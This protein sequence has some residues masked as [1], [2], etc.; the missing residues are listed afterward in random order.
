MGPREPRHIWGLTFAAQAFVRRDYGIVSVHNPLRLNEWSETAPDIALLHPESPRNQYPSPRFTYAVIEVADTTLALDRHIKA[1]LYAQ[2][3]IPEYWIVDL[4]GEQI[5][6]YREPAADGYRAI[7]LYGRGEH[8]SPAFA[9]DMV[10]AVDT[11]L[12][13]IATESDSAEP[14]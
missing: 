1:P 10:V 13:P 12:G 14:D 8:L 5:E 7:R 9:P 11:I 2:A 3:G 4:N 6:V